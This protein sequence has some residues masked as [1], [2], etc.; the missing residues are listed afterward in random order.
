MV[1]HFKKSQLRS[2]KFLFESRPSKTG[3]DEIQHLTH[4]PRKDYSNFAWRKP[5]LH[6]L[7]II[8]FTKLAA[9]SS[10]KISGSL[11]AFDLKRLIGHLTMSSSR[12]VSNILYCPKATGAS[13]ESIGISPELTQICYINPVRLDM[14]NTTLSNGVNHAI[15]IAI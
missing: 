1:L 15:L 13:T 8:I 6:R 14:K 12:G 5:K 2:I 10:R 4:L 3:R 7:V 11:L 9:F